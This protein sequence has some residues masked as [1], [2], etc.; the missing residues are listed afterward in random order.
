[1]QKISACIVIYNGYEE[2]FAA[3]ASVLQY[4]KK[5]ALTLYLVDNA[6]PD[7]S[8]AAMEQAIAAGALPVSENQTVKLICSKKNLGFGGGHNLVIPTLDSEYHFV[9]NPDVLVK[10]DVLSEMAAYA[11]QINHTAVTKL[12]M[13]RPTLTF[14]DGQ[15]QILPLRRC[16][17]RALIYRQLPQLKF[18][19]RYHDRYVMQNE[20]RTKPVEIAFCTG[21]F[22]MLQ[23]QSFCKMGGFDEGYFMYVED[24]DLTQKAMLYGAVMLLPQFQAVHAWHRAP[25]SN[26]SHFTL[27]IKSMVR[28]F[29]KWGFKL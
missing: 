3:A 18:L 7:G 26:L 23:T 29:K 22:S 17:V 10:D 4:T 28:Y 16:T 25:H 5:A 2:A 9:L 11:T 1:M 13:A 27:Q 15:E 21:S 19:K 12:V 6:S 14:P 20:D 8:G 24:A